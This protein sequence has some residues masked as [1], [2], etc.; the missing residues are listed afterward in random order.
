M[1]LESNIA[2]WRIA[3]VWAALSMLGTM[4]AMPFLFTLLDTLNMSNRPPLPMLV[5]VSVLQTGVLAFLLSWAGTAAGRKLQI[6][7]P[8]I[9][10]WLAR[11]PIEIPKSMAL[12]LLLGAASGIV[13]IATD[14][15]FAPYM[16]AL[17]DRAP[18]QPSPLQ[19]L[20]ASAYG[21]IS[22]EVQMRLGA[23][24][25]FAWL[26]AH[27]FGFQDRGRTL[28]L[29]LGVLFGA[30]V[31][32]AGHLPLAFSIWPPSAVVVTRILLL[33]A[34]V[35][36]IAGYMYIHRGLEHAVV[37]HFTAD[38]VLYVIRPLLQS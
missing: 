18:P 6:G 30:L 4:L 10:N 35:G 25:L 29:S 32:G 11:K 2:T 13:V 3:A 19:G 16:P 38:I 37:L 31:F 1:N 9:E 7:S 20:L 17:I 14:A 27:L 23:T 8:F 22:E 12:A 26:V 5:V 15:L 21:G 36:L 33:N 34:I 24:T 28:S